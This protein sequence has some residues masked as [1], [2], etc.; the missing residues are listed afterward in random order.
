MFELIVVIQLDEE[1]TLSLHT[2]KVLGFSHPDNIVFDENVNP[3]IL[4][5]RLPPG[6]VI[7]HHDPF[8]IAKGL[9]Q[10]RL[11]A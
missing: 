8:P 10:Q 1:L 2:R 11:Q 6:S 3:T 5:L 4:D 9:S 7:E